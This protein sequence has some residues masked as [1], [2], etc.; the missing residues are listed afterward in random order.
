MRWRL[1]LGF[2]LSVPLAAFALVAWTSRDRLVDDA[3]LVAAG[4]T[5][6]WDHSRGLAVLLPP[7]WRRVEPDEK[8][9]DDDVDL[10]DLQLL[11]AGPALVGVDRSAARIGFVLVQR[12]RGPA[13]VDVD[14][15]V[16]RFI[17]G[18]AAKPGYTFL[19]R[20][21]I[22]LP[23]G[24]GVEFRF[25]IAEGF[26]RG[27]YSRIMLTRPGE[28]VSISRSSDP[29]REAEFTSLFRKIAESV[30]RLD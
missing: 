28:I 19:G 8:R 2:V 9:A 1:F 7:G 14:A 23:A 21:T 17:R 3:A 15:V 29:K 6:Q 25:R 20:S 13:G 16:E 18:L 12:E 4:W 22:E 11:A 24:N 10:R 30:R 27:M 26:D 5:M